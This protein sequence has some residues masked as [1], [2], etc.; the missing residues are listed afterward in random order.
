MT[1]QVKA[2]PQTI[3]QSSTAQDVR[4]SEGPHEVGQR[5]GWIRQHE[6]DGVRGGRCKP[7]QNLLVDA[8]VRL[9]Q[10]EPPVRIRSVR[11]TTGLF[12]GA[13]GDHHEGGAVEV[14][15]VA[16]PNVYGWRQ[17]GAVLH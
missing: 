4:E 1:R 16:R 13:S 6:D 3:E 12:V 5:I 14:W 10:P 9:E 17:C 8:G 11:R 2:K 15:V 7:R